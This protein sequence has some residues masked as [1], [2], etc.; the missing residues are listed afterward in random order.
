MAQKNWENRTNMD[1]ILSFKGQATGQTWCHTSAYHLSALGLLCGAHF[2]RS[3]PLL[4]GR[5]AFGLFAGCNVLPL[6]L[7]FSDG[8]ILWLLL[9]R[10]ILS[11]HILQLHILVDIMSL[12]FVNSFFLRTLHS[13][14]FQSKFKCL[15][16]N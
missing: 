2:K 3:F 15:P 10:R 7:V 11:L 1:I 4:I 12:P 6:Y 5:L 14:I 8:P 13:V 9:G 16:V